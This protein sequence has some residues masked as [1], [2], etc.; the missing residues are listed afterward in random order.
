MLEL[1]AAPSSIDEQ[2][3]RQLVIDIEAIRPDRNKVAHTEKVDAALAR[4]IREAVLGRHGR[5]GLLY[6][7]ISQLNPPSGLPHAT[8]SSPTTQTA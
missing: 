6:R 2:A 1:V 4:T 3:L 8:L 7:L 5:P